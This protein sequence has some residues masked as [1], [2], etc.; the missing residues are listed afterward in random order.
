MNL[1]NVLLFR[2]TLLLDPFWPGPI[3]RPNSTE[4]ITAWVGLC[5]KFPELLSPVGRMLCCLGFLTENPSAVVSK[6]FKDFEVSSTF[7]LSKL[8]FHYLQFGTLSSLLIV[9]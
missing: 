8:N 7:L 1:K 5:G 9:H 4:Q 3:S 6:W 2:P